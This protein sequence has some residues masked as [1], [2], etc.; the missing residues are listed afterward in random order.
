MI[1]ISDRDS[2]KFFIKFGVDEI[3]VDDFRRM[4]TPKETR[5][6]GTTASRWPARRWD[7]SQKASSKLWDQGESKTSSN[8][9]ALY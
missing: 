6:C 7:R 3:E 9:H 2:M 4:R 1:M 5:S 8:I